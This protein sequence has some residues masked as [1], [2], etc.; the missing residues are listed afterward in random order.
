MGLMKWKFLNAMGRK[1]YARII[2]LTLEIGVSPELFT[3]SFGEPPGVELPMAANV[4]QMSLIKTID[5]QFLNCGIC[6]GRFQQPKVLP[7]LHTFCERCLTGYVPAESLTL[8]CPVCRQQSIL[9]EEGVTALQTNVF[10]T[11]VMQVLETPTP[12]QACGDDSITAANKCLDCA[13][14]L[15][16]ECADNHREIELTQDHKVV[17][18]N[19]LALVERDDD[20]RMNMLL[21][22]ANHHGQTLRSNIFYCQDCE[23]AICCTCTDLE[24]QGHLTMHM[25]EAVDEQKETLQSLLNK[26]HAQVP[27]LKEAIDLV[28]DLE[29]VL[30]NRCAEAEN[31]INVC[32]DSLKD[33]LEQRRQLLLSELDETYSGKQHILCQQRELLDACLNN[34]T[35]SC[36]FTEKA[37]NHGSDTEVLI[38]QKMPEENDYLIFNESDL[39]AVK[40]CIYNMG[41]IQS[42]SAIAFET[43]AAGEGLRHCIVGHPSL[44]TVISKDRNCDLVKVGHSQITAEIVSITSPIC[45]TAKVID[46]RN[47]S[48][49]LT[50]TIPKEGLYQLSIR[51][52]DQH[53]KGSPF[54]IKAILEEESSS[55]DRPSSKIPRTTGVRQHAT[56]RTP[57]AKSG[58]SNRRSNP[59]EDD[60]LL[61]VGFKGRNKGEFT[62]PQGVCCSNSGKIIIADSNNQ[63]L[64]VFT[65]TGECKLRFGIRGRS[66]GQLQR[67]TGVACLDNGNY[68]VA[69]YDNK[70]V[71]IFEPSGKFVNRIGVGKLLGPKGVAVDQDGHI[72]VV[73]NKASCII[74]FQTNGKMINKFGS[75]GNQENQFAGPHFVAINNKNQIVVSDFHNH[76]IKVFDP[77]GGFLM[78]FGSNGE[79]NGQFNAPTGIAVDS[80]DNI[81]VADWGNSRIQV[82]DCNG[83]FLSYVNTAADPL[84]GPQGL[85]LTDSGHVVVADSG[86][87][88]FKLY[89]YLQ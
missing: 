88:C 76:C 86:N 26:A 36:E 44:V 13:D 81:L 54:R 61:R 78:S 67:P 2:T 56:K 41:S 32:F 55:S 30:S 47:G 51:L 39:P 25:E 53:V 66:A 11:N 73:D 75:R 6:L 12:C 79:G 7:C 58:G 59:I 63:C 34:L 33:V 35:S 50:Y 5:K 23:T 45:Y 20:E 38:I 84:Y 28:T 4:N 87:H 69:D 40:K 8:T 3:S 31:R 9:P 89:K 24:H 37:L 72:V 16:D 18:L 77:D 60:L 80:Q 83:S 71:S 49:D 65:S 22:C 19:E 48:Y 57:S 46:H 17:T 70:W 14:F 62:N 85:S 1:K 21:L 82:F 10:I 42:N 27:V 64:Q 43:T 52:F 29:T 15:C 74:V 68:V